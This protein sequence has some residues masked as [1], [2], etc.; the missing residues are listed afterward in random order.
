MKNLFLPLILLVS[1]ITVK[2]VAQD[3]PKQAVLKRKVF[4]QNNSYPYPEEI[5]TAL[6]RVYDNKNFETERSKMTLAQANLILWN[7]VA[8][9]T[10]YTNPYL[11]LKRYA[12]YKNEVLNAYKQIG[13]DAATQDCISSMFNSVESDSTNAFNQYTWEYPG[14]FMVTGGDTLIYKYIRANLNELVKDENGELINTSFSGNY[15]Y[16]DKG[17]SNYVKLKMH[18]GIKVTAEYYNTDLVPQKLEWYYPSGSLRYQLVFTE[19]GKKSY[20]T[21]HY[22]YTEATQKQVVYNEN[23]RYQSVINYDEEGNVIHEMY[24]NPSGQLELSFGIVRLKDSTLVYA[25]IDGINEF[26]HSTYKDGNGYIEINSYENGEKKMLSHQEY[27]NY[28]LDGRTIEYDTNAG[29]SE[30]VFVAGEISYMVEYYKSGDLKRETFFKEGQK[31][32]VIEYPKFKR[33]KVK[34]EGMQPKE[35]WYTITNTENYEE[36]KAGNQI[37]CSN[38][39]QVLAEIFSNEWVSKNLDIFEHENL[40]YNVYLKIKPN[41]EIYDVSLYEVNNFK[42]VDEEA[43]LSNANTKLSTLAFSK[44]PKLKET[45]VVN[46]VASFKVTVLND[47]N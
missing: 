47:S 30:K 27:K 43:F 6:Y 37:E 2:S 38:C 40:E 28:L 41:K 16:F 44:F 5:I 39:D 42:N 36:R 32:R 34:I 21:Y 20:E 29:K 45:E 12:P 8:N 3:T 14:C 9:I 23:E 1:I 19:S 13:Y 4:Y 7:S 33:S 22:P 24:Y 11:Q 17:K 31:D 15:S 26:G 46:M 35:D 25:P 18:N 10:S